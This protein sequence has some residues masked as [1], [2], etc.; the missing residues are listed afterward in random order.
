MLC[1]EPDTAPKVPLPV[2]PYAP[3]SNT[4]FLVPTRLSIKNG[5]SISSAV[6]A[7][8]TAERPYTL[9]RIASPPEKLSFSIGDLDRITRVHKPNGIL[10]GSAIFA[11]LTTVTD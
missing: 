7:Q 6:F 2:W 4:W 3:L 9:Q 1:N 5:I 8:L 11:E 10:I